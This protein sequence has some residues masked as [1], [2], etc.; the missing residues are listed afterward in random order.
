MAHKYIKPQDSGNRGETRYSVLKSENGEAIRFNAVNKPFSFNANHFTLNQ[1]I[2]AEHIED[3]PDTNTTFASI[4][5]FVRGTGSGS[6]GP[7]PSKEHLIN[8]GYKKPLEFTF[9][10]VPVKK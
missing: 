4:D 5:G 2:A 6:C 9:E 1:L 7:A 3:L 10:I 8:F